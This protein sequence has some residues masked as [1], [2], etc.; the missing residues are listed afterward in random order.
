MKQLLLA[1]IRHP[2]ITIALL[3]IVIGFQFQEQIFDL[4]EPA[5]R[6]D[7]QTHAAELDK[8]LDAASSKQ[9]PADTSTPAV[10][11]VE[12]TPPSSAADEEPAAAVAGSEEAIEPAAPAVAPEPG[13]ASHDEKSVVQDSSV[14][15]PPQ[16]AT[17]EPP[18]VTDEGVEVEQTAQAV[19]QA[20]QP[21]A[22]RTYQEQIEMARVT[23]H[24]GNPT[25]A[26]WAYQRVVESF[27]EQLDARGEWADLLLRFRRWPQAME[28]Y[29]LVLDA[30]YST[31]QDERAQRI[32]RVLG[33]YSPA[34]ARDLEAIVSPRGD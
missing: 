28:Q 26:L 12:S 23:A 2:V 5:S 20:A 6:S 8:P 13:M 14:E 29:R 22:G 1:P 33:Q 17:P 18:V 21:E 19:T 27:P 11:A 4:P 32:V 25:A 15:H 31:G 10:A 16:L 7:A 3:F 24:R 34:F 30:L 9:A